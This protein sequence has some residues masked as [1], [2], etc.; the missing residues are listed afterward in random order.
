M[1]TIS[2]YSEFAQ[3]DHELWNLISSKKKNMESALAWISLQIQVFEQIM[4]LKECS[5]W[6]EE[7]KKRLQWH[8]NKMLIQD[9]ARSKWGLNLFV[10]G[11]KT[12]RLVESCGKYHHTQLYCSLPPYHFGK[13]F[14]PAPLYQKKIVLKAITVLNCKLKFGWT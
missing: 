11:A 5:M 12:F 2:I 7:C 3:D 8:K 13:R 1:N 14:L 10:F 6:M 9:H 4:M